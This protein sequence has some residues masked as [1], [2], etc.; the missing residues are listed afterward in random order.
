MVLTLPFLPMETEEKSRAV[1][2]AVYTH[3]AVRAEFARWNATIYTSTY[4]PQYE[5]LGTGEP[6]FNQEDWRGKT[7]RAGGG[8]GQAMRLLGATPASSTATEVYTGVQQGTMDAASFPF[9]YGHV[10]YRIHE[11]TDWFT[12][13]LAP[14][15][16]DCPVL[17]ATSAY[18]ALSSDQKQLLDDIRE[19]VDAA[20]LAAYQAVDEINLAML[21]E[22]LQE[23]RYTPE[24]RSQL[25]D[26]VGRQVIEDWI[27]AN[28][29]H[30]PAR[31]LVEIT[32]R[33]AGE[34]YQ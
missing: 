33:A 2:Q 28:Q 26:T 10:S 5:I 34:S 24:Q 18:E 17:L 12:S 7:I 8:I 13:N 9:T 23:I 3:P 6:P 31:E 29:D 14:G 19:E 15:S 11:V 25:R 16:A 4:L 30:F 32:F 21:R 22:S 20:Q 27:E 1:R